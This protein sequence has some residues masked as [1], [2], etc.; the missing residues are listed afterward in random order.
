MPPLKGLTFCSDFCR[1]CGS[2]SLSHVLLSSPLSKVLPIYRV[3]L[4]GLIMEQMEIPGFGQDYS[5]VF[6]P[7]IPINAPFGVICS[8]IGFK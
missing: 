4:V 7:F 2:F 1:E 6:Q 3:T 8:I 5:N